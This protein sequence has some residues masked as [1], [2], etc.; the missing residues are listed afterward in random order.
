MF[1]SSECHGEIDLGSLPDD[2][3]SRLAV[4]PGEWLEFDP[5]SSTIVVRHTQPTDAPVVPTA[6]S[7]LV[8]ML[9]E[10]PYDLQTRIPGGDFLIHTEATGELVRL[11]VRE[12]GALEIRWAHPDYEGATKRPYGDGHEIVIEPWEQ[13]LNGSIEFMSREPQEAAKNLQDL[14]DTFEGLHPEGDFRAVAAEGGCVQVDMSVVN[15]DARLLVDRCIEL[16]EPRTL[17][18]RVDVSSFGDARPEHL[19]RFLF[20]FGEVWVQHP[21][22]WSEPPA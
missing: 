2:V 10:I 12:G 15:L 3:R 22:L 11:R 18:G 13:R 17:A 19:V 14:A 5:H 21:L 7:E 9:D 16:A 1:H 4:L 8:R 6:A 20:E